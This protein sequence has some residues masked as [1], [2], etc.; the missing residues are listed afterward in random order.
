MELNKNKVIVSDVE[1]NNEEVCLAKEFAA[2][3]LLGS[4]KSATKNPTSRDN[5]SHLSQLKKSHDSLQASS[6]HSNPI[7]VASTWTRKESKIKG[8]MV[9]TK[10]PL[11]KKKVT[12]V[13]ADLPVVSVKRFQVNP[14]NEKSPSVVVEAV[15]QPCQQQ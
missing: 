3:K 11:G 9:E 6:L 13:E 4:G 15:V 10:Q 12:R 2:T 5:L 1:A 14:R 8:N 7:R